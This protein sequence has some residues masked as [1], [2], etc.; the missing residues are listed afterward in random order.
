MRVG[1]NSAS[2]KV[3][4]S[5]RRNSPDELV[6][7]AAGRVPTALIGAFTAAGSHS[8]LVKTETPQLVTGIRL[9]N[10]GASQNLPRLSAR[11]QQAA[12]RRA[13]S[14]PGRRPAVSLPRNNYSAACARALAL[15]LV[16]RRNH[17]IESKQRRGVARLVVAHR[18]EHGDVGPF[19]GGRGPFSL[20]ILRTV[21]RNSRSS[22]GFAPIT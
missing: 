11:L 22:A 4:S 6:T 13:P 19:A 12:W 10:T 8:I 7:Y 18:L 14:C 1:G 20:S 5:E 16:E 21:S 2:L 17:G 9:G 3:V 15:D